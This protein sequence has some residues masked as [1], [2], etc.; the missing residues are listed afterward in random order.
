MPL[1]NTL[2]LFRGHLNIFCHPLSLYNAHVTLSSLIGNLA[3][4]LRDGVLGSLFQAGF[5]H[6][7]PYLCFFESTEALSEIN[8]LV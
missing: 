5:T 8:S 4:F 3:F 6:S 1:R 7:L 2:Y